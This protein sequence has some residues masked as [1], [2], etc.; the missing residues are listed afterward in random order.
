MQVPGM[1]RVWAQR[2][3]RFRPYRT[4]QDLIENGVL[5]GA[6][7]RKIKDYIVAHRLNP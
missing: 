4:K 1:T 2:I 7:Y 5:P 6:V 3:A